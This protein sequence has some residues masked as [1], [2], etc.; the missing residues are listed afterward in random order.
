MKPTSVKIESSIKLDPFEEVLEDVR[1]GKTIVMV[2]DE[3][4]ENEGDLMVAAEKATAENINFMLSLIHISE[5]T[6]PY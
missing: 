6:R 2:D 1:S 5:P 3:D 4:R